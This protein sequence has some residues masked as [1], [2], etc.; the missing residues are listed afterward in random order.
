MS[1]AAVATRARAISLRRLC[2]VLVLAVPFVFSGSSPCAWAELGCSYCR[3]ECFQC[4][5]PWGNCVRQFSDSLKPANCHLC[6]FCRFC[7]LCSFTTLACSHVLSIAALLMAM[8]FRPSRKELVAV[9]LAVTFLAGSTHIITRPP[10]TPRLELEEQTHFNF[11]FPLKGD[12]SSCEMDEENCAVLVLKPSGR[13]GNCFVALFNALE[14][15]YKCGG[16]IMPKNYD[17][18]H[19]HVPELLNPR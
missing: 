4:E 12:E 13:M 15:V 16:V 1:A 2:A 19:I 5:A 6:S 14:Y 11:A 17:Y 9:F 3:S 8:C 7:V 10:P 18:R